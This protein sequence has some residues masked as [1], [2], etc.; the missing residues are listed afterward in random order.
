MKLQIFLWTKKKKKAFVSFS[1]AA[2]WFLFPKLL[3]FSFSRALLLSKYRFVNFA[4][5]E[6]LCFFPAPNQFFRSFY[7]PWKLHQMDFFQVPTKVHK[8]YIYLLLFQIL[9]YSIS[10]SR[11]FC[12]SC[13][14][15]SHWKNEF[16]YSISTLESAQSHKS[17]SSITLFNK[18]VE[19]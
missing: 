17:S 1:L 13:L 2:E 8:L 9:Y 7:K 14:W 6:E 3:L 16:C 12:I 10:S 18:V 5:E 11:S 15:F 4:E 19:T